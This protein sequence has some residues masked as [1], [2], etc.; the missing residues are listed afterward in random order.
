M[1]AEEREIEEI[2]QRGMARKI[3]RT[4]GQQEYANLKQEL[5]EEEA[6]INDKMARL[7]RT[8]AGISRQNKKL[9]Q[10]GEEFDAR[11]AR[12]RAEMFRLIQLKRDMER[13][14]A[15]TQATDDV[16]EGVSK[17]TEHETGE[18]EGMASGSSHREGVEM[19][20]E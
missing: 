15:E 3:D 20:R 5:E 16:D 12:W 19:S 18:G 1:G 17:G 14:S 6:K 4:A 11:S 2:L 9:Q 13:T 7:R 8:R 10:E